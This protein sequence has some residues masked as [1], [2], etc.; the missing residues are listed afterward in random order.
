MA[1]KPWYEIN[2]ER[3]T[4]NE[5][6]F[7]RPEDFPW[8]KTLEDNWRTIRDEIQTLLARDERR[9]SPYFINLS[10]PPKQWKTMGIYFWKYKIHKNC[11]ACPQTARLLE[12]LP[13]MTGG[14]LSALEPGSNINPHH[15]DTN[16]IVRIHLGL[17]IPA[18]MPQC[19]FQVGKEI[20]EWREGKAL[21]FCDAHPHSAW[22]HSDQ[23]RIVLIV[24]VMK[25]EFASQTDAIC[26]HVLATSGLQVLYQ[27]FAVLRRMPRKLKFTIHFFMRTALRVILPL[28]RRAGFLARG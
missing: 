25:P 21:L 5:P 4:G 26:S 9:L 17:S 13:N 16:A 28:Q 2:G 12:S 19:G 27:Q 14:S 3:F 6:N 8:I 10:F 18:G 23:R 24:D 15:G 22:N 20:R 7:Y 1:I 11:R